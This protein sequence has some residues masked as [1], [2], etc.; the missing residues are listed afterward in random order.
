MKPVYL[1]AP[2]WMG[3]FNAPRAGVT[4]HNWRIMAPIA[5]SGTPLE[6][7]GTL[8]SVLADEVAAFR[9]EEQLPVVIAG[10]C[11]FSIGVVAGLQRELSDFTIV[12][13]DAHG[14][15]NTAETTPSGFIGGM[16]LAMLCGLGDQTIVTAAKG[17]THPDTDVILTDARDLDP[18]EKEAVSASNIVHLADVSELEA[19]DL[20]DKPIYVHFDTDVLRTDDMGAVDYPAS[21]GASLETIEAVLT[22]LAK[23]G[24]IAA[25]SV[26]MWNPEM[27]DADQTNEQAVVGIIERFVEQLPK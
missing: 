2:Y 7:M 15:F 18:G 8:C 19:V 13:F 25:I 27:D 6:R 11:T 24:Q 26:T 23:T 10:D 14:D 21:G 12:W 1:S 22:R 16:P 9:Q 5:L 3:E 17:K 4:R 20:P